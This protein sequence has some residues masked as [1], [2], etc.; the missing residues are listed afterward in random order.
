MDA[1][2]EGELSRREWENE[3]RRQRYDPHGDHY[4]KE[5]FEAFKRRVYGNKTGGEK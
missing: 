4:T 3:Q 1:Y 2:Q 5:D